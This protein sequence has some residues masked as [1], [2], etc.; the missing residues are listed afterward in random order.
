[1]QISLLSTA[2][3]HRPPSTRV[4]WWSVGFK[5]T[6]I[7]LVFADWNIGTGRK[8][9]SKSKWTLS[10]LIA[11]VRL[12]RNVCLQYIEPTRET[13]GNHSTD[14]VEIRRWCT[15]RK[16][17]EWIYPFE[18]KQLSIIQ[19]SPRR[20]KKKK[21]LFDSPFRSANSFPLETYLWT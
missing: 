13:G 9:Q 2:S 20:L 16:S 5:R 11:V 19:C 12:C 1:M 14:K 7:R 18:F 6:T 3:I 15:V 8:P 10:R 21:K 17:R 4:M